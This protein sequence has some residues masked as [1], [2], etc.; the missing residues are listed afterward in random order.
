[1]RTR[2][3]IAIGLVLAMLTPLF[4]GV[5]APLV[6]A[7]SHREAPLIANDPAADGTDFYMFRSPDDPERAPCT[8]S[9]TTSRCKPRYGGPNFH[10][11]GDDV[12]YEVKIDNDGDAVADIIYQFD[13]R[14]E[15]NASAVGGPAGDTYLYNDG[16]I[17]SLDD[18]NLLFRQYYTLTRQTLDDNERTAQG[19]PR[20]IIARGQV[21][22][23]L[24]RQRVLL[25]R[26]QRLRRPGLHRSARQ[27]QLRGHRR[28]P[29]IVA[30]DEGGK[31]YVGPRQS[32]STSTWRASST[33]PLGSSTTDERH[34]RVQRHH[35]GH[36]GPDQRLLS[37]N[38]RPGH[39]RLDDGQPPGNADHHRPR[40]SRQS[41]SA[42]SCRCRAW[43]T[44]WS[45]R[46]SSAPR[47]RTGSTPASP[48]TTSRTSATTSSTRAWP[49]SSTSSST[50]AP[51]TTGRGDLVQI[52]VTGIPGLDPAA[53]PDR[54]GRDAAPQHQHSPSPARMTWASSAATRRASP[55]AGASPTTWSTSS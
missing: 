10:H 23:G 51:R 29:A 17:T 35:A 13:F 30:T 7:S 26:R 1:M 24:R 31:V 43:A 16:S 44:R 48:R 46:S 50:S 33:W 9:P 15:R 40:I 52:F 55:T 39:R 18:P 47:T 42:R 37:A 45:T 34:H 3:T 20:T 36:Q 49:R 19:G 8:S 6:G 54:S 4:A 28:K 53:E 25:P 32:R 27:G 11:P 22:P 12:L 5:F 14:S 21:V 2:A 38:Q 41:T